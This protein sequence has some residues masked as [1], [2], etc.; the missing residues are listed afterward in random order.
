MTPEQLIQSGMLEAYVLG[1]LPP[2]EAEL[3]ERSRA[4]D[5]RIAKELEEIE[6]ALERQAMLDAV[7]APPMV[8]QQI[9]TRIGQEKKSKVMDIR[10]KDRSSTPWWAVA[11]GVA[12][13]ISAGLNVITLSQVNDLRSELARL[14]ADRSVLAEEL[15]VQ[16]ASLERSQEML[17]V[18]SD[19]GTRVITLAGTDNA[20]GASAR[21]YWNK[22]RQQ[23]HL[24]VIQLA[25]AP[26]GKQ[27]QLWALVDGQPVDAGVF[28]TGTDTLQLMKRI[29][30]A[31]AFAVTIEVEGGSPTPAI[32]T[33]VL[34]GQVG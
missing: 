26:Q 1:Q 23:V 27:Y 33:L 30:Q 2:H 32:E 4:Q 31:Q 29:P 15:Q 24:D 11:A 14:E 7:P 34:M 5:K 20:P 12:F 10:E 8:W 22:E 28:D 19:P 17:A 18:I 16:R 6:I 25:Q 21:I 9:A 13:L 3:V